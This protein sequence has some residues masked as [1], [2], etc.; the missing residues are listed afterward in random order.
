MCLSPPCQVPQRQLRLGCG[1]THL[2]L[3]HSVI[4]KDERKRWQIH[5]PGLF[6]SFG[7]S[8]KSVKAAHWQSK[9]RI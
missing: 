2:V 8:L 9:A 1:T 3:C 7:H 6:P 4:H 5:L